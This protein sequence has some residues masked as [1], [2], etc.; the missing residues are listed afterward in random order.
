MFLMMNCL[1]VFATT[2]GLLYAVHSRLQGP[3]LQQLSLLMAEGF[4]SS[5]HSCMLCKSWYESTTVV[6]LLAVSIS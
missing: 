5:P 6:V 2:D 3:L 1:L 4:L